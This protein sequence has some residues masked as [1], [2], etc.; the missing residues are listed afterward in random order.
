M[1]QFVSERFLLDRGLTNYWGYSTLGF[2]AP[3]AAYSAEGTLGQQVT[4]LSPVVSS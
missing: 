4:E 1:H 3:H 2:F